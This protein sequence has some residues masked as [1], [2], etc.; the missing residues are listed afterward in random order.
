M[1][2][3]STGS[4]SIKSAL[5]KGRIH[6]CIMHGST[7]SIR[8]RRLQQTGNCYPYS[9]RHQ[10][11]VISSNLSILDYLKQETCADLADIVSPS[12]SA[13]TYLEQ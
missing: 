5:G 10:P 7:R 3:I 8:L 1:L 13:R 9:Y 12:H 2:L 4:I 11:I 6:H